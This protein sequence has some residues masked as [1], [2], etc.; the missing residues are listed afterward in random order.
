[1][2][3]EALPL[4]LEGVTF[5]LSKHDLNPDEPP[6]LRNLLKSLG[7]KQ[8]FAASAATHIVTRNVDAVASHNAVVVTPLWVVN[9]AKLNLH[10]PEQYFSPNL[11]SAPFGG[12]VVAFHQ[13]AFEDV[14]Q[15]WGIVEYFGGTCSAEL[16]SSCTHL[17]VAYEDDTLIG[18][19]AWHSKLEIV[20][21]QWITDC[22]RARRRLN[23]D[24]YR[25]TPRAAELDET[26]TSGLKSPVLFVGSNHSLLQDASGASFTPIPANQL[27]EVDPDVVTMDVAQSP[28]ICRSDDLPNPHTTP[29][30]HPIATA[31]VVSEQPKLSQVSSSIESLQD[32]RELPLLLNTDVLSL[33]ICSVDE[34]KQKNILKLWA[35]CIERFGGVIEPL[36]D[37]TT[38]AVTDS[39]AT[40]FYGEAFRHHAVVVSPHW[41]NDLYR[42]AKRPGFADK[43][44]YVPPVHNATIPDMSSL[45]VGVSGFRGLDRVYLTDMLR[46]IGCQYS[47]GLTSSADILVCKHAGTQKEVFARRWGLTV[48]NAG[49]IEDC[50]LRWQRV[51]ISARHRQLDDDPQS[52]GEGSHARAAIHSSTD[53][54]DGP[55]LPSFS[56]T[57]SAAHAP[58]FSPA[59][60]LS[61]VAELSSMELLHGSNSP[62]NAGLS[63][64]PVQFAAAEPVAPAG[65]WRFRNSSPTNRTV[66]FDRSRMGLQAP[67]S[68]AQLQSHRPHL[69]RLVQA[70]SLQQPSRPQSP[71]PPREQPSPKIPEPDPATPSKQSQLLQPSSAVANAS[72][73][74]ASGKGRAR[75]PQSRP[76]PVA[77]LMTSDPETAAAV[78]SAAAK[79]IRRPVIAISRAEALRNVDQAGLDALVARVAAMGGK[80]LL[81]FGENIRDCTHLVASS[82]VPRTVKCAAALVFCHHVVT[83]AWLEAC[84]QARSFA[85]VDPEQYAITETLFSATTPVIRARALARRAV[86]VF[87]GIDFYF[88]T[89]INP[90][91]DTLA[92]LV[93][94]GGG[95]LLEKLPQVSTLVRRTAHLQPDSWQQ[96]TTKPLVIITQVDDDKRATGDFARTLLNQKVKLF[97][98]RFLVQA[99]GSQEIDW[100]CQAR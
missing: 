14:P 47:T 31:A 2:E 16:D 39:R 52:E 89:P 27:I 25:P 78:M 1:M 77:E 56:T 55:I 40:E 37:R 45:V 17:V 99:L 96:G 87:H 73:S 26:A 80:L 24:Y 58:S 4:L 95:N 18:L 29:L 65:A 21:K 11:A 28:P 53:P 43:A 59:P 6:L 68:S 62:T 41:L 61:P 70:A 66:Q 81:D 10:L 32:S 44:V 22:A 15:L 64:P 98:V 49:W 34:S 50:Y 46:F 9:C 36:S 85:S 35:A 74:A 3:V 92:I 75:T 84:L 83:M 69:P 71:P 20:T 60:S 51:P 93:N 67:S 38:L 72:N 63:S 97:D 23:C 90:S 8:C 30:E 79:P 5:L 86:P 88:I 42:D 48:V 7:A 13:I 82:P 76:V 12:A 33:H 100:S 91:T 54:G 57:A 19:R 94:V